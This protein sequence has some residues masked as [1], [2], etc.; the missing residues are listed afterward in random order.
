MTSSKAWGTLGEA[1]I[2]NSKID[3]N[4]ILELNL[5]QDNC[6]VYWQGIVNYTLSINTGSTQDQLRINSGSTQDQLRIHLG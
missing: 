2:Q 6:E 3:S 4:K 5:I 1:Y